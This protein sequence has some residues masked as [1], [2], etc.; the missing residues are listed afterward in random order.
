MKL[1]QNRIQSGLAWKHND[2]SK[3]EKIKGRRSNYH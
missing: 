1:Q 2:I 3:I